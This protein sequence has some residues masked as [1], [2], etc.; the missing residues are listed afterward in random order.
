MKKDKKIKILQDILEVQNK[1]IEE[2]RLEN[3][4]LKNR[5]YKSENITDYGYEKAKELQKELEQ[6]ME[7]YDS[8]IQDCVNIKEAYKKKLNELKVLGKRYKKDMKKAV[9]QI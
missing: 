8:M 6:K 4:Q 9:N 3:E 7:I 1:E 5:I 2:L